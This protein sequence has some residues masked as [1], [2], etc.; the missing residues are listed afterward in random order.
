VPKVGKMVAHSVA[1]WV[2]SMAVKMVAWMAA[3]LAHQ[4]V[5]RLADRKVAL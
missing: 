4:K 1:Q 3:M 5:G 2:V